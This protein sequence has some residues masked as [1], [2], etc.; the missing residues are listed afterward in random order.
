[1]SEDVQ[2]VEGPP[3][4]IP[5][6]LQAQA[7]G[8]VAAYEA[9]SIDTLVERVN[10][11]KELMKRCMVEGQHHGTI[12]GTKKPSLWKPGA[13]L[14]CTLF[15]LGTRYPKD[16]VRIERDNGHFLF[17][18]TCELFHIPTGRVVGEGV[19]AGSTMEYR[20]RVQ[21]ED[22]YT[23]HGQPIKAKYTPFDFYN[24]V[25]KMAKKRA[26]V[27]AVLTASGASEIFTADVEDMPEDLR[28]GLDADGHA[29]GSG[30]A[31]RRTLPKAPKHTGSAGPAA[32]G[33]QTIEGVVER[34]W[35]NDYQ[36]KRYY[37]AK[38]NGQQLQT[39]DEKVGQSLLDAVGKQVRAEVD[40]SPKPGKF[41]VKGVQQKEF[42]Q[43]A[44]A[45]EPERKDLVNPGNTAGVARENARKAREAAREQYAQQ[46]V[47]APPPA[48]KP[49]PAPASHDSIPMDRTQ[50][51]EV[52]ERMAAVHPAL[53][54]FWLLKAAKRLG[55]IQESTHRLADMDS[56]ALGVLLVRWT[57]LLKAARQE[58]AGTAEEAAPPQAA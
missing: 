30:Q 10:L 24:T 50:Y 52:C 35:P 31:A 9:V 2:T 4:E 5:K 19:G 38:V 14:I 46:G 34:A 21:T 8:A 43:P 25:L 22:R 13:E 42:P 28:K 1:M 16:S 3:V 32:G 56:T 58:E 37:F 55:W 51:D 27:D 45:A 12:P 18:L 47:K 11:L 57:D 26:M 20:F 40:P 33:L 29:G 7:A 49:I 44:A 6:D 23:D 41:Y 54:E 17:T 39:T 36:S 53:K 15:Q 48:A